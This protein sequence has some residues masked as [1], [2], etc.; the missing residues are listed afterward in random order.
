M[1]DLS[2]QT[3][4][5]LLKAGDQIAFERI[6][7]RYWAKVYHFTSLFIKDSYEKE[8]I[9][10]SVFIRL[11]DVRSKIDPSRDPDGL[12]FIITRNL[13]FNQAHRSANEQAMKDALSRDTLLSEET[14]SKLETADLDYY[15]NSLISALPPRQ[16][17]AF[18]LSRNEGLSY[19]EIAERMKISEKG[20]ERNLYLA[21]KFIK[22]KLPLFLIFLGL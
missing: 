5:A 21:R 6:Y 8:E 15:I 22:D 16:R 4:L 7:R 9:V 12:L 19:K 10:Q 1:N 14:E 2:L 13:V 3:D 17:Q 11:W 20:V 18:E